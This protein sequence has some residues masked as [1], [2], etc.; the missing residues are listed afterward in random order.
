LLHCAVGLRQRQFDFI[1]GWKHRFIL[2]TAHRY[3]KLRAQSQQEQRHVFILM[4]GF[5]LSGNL[6]GLSVGQAIQNSYDQHL[7]VKD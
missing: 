6:H 1:V 7:K 2:G 4:L 3:K 5:G